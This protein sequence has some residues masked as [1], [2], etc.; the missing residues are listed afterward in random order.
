MDL[1]ELSLC[2]QNGN[3]KKTVE[4]VIQAL[5]EKKKPEE[6]LKEGLISAMTEVG[7][8]FTNNEIYVP[9]MLI[10]A[11]AMSA[12]MKILE[13]ILTETGIKPIGV[14]VI[15]TVKGDL[16]DIGKNLVKMMLKGAG[17]EVVDLGV[18]VAAAAF[19]ATAEEIKAD[20]ICLSALLTTTMPAMEEVIVAFKDAGVRDKYIVMI[21]GAPITDIYAQQIGAD[22]YSPD[23]A[24]AA[25]AAK[26]ALAK[27]A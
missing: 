27:K 16:H 10:A 2:V 24:L 1:K 20:I 6:I 8:K 19:L 17:L 11:R 12:G 3:S 15:G 14:A 26:D 7:A 18:D 23:G 9:E 5:D 13:P 25:Q 4:L 22:I 21:G